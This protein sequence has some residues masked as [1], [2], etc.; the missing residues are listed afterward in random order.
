ME[1]FLVLR[2]AILTKRKA[3]CVQKDRLKKFGNDDV[4]IIRTLLN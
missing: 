4:I 2:Y 3:Q 1:R